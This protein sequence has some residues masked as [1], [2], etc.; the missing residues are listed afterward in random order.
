MSQTEQYL[1]HFD[2]DNYTVGYDYPKKSYYVT[3]KD[4]TTYRE[5][6]QNFL[7]VL[8]ALYIDITE[9]LKE[10]LLEC[11]NRDETIGEANSLYHT[12]ESTGLYIQSIQFNE[13]SDY[14]LCI[15][16]NK[17]ILYI[18]NSN[19][20]FDLKA[21]ESLEIVIAPL[22]RSYYKDTLGLSITQEQMLSICKF[23]IYF[24]KP[25][26]V[27][28]MTATEETTLNPKELYY[29]NT[30]KL[31][32]FNNTS[33]AEYTCINNP[34]NQYTYT[35]IGD[36]KAIDS[37]TSSI[38]LTEP[39][40]E[41][42]IQLYNL[43]ENSQITITGS[44][45]VIE[46]EEYTDDNTYTISSIHGDT[47]SVKEVIP[48]YYSFPY[49]EC[50]VIGYSYNIESIDHE[51]NSITLAENPVSE[52][53]LVGDTIH[54]SGA[55]INRGYTILEIDGTYTV[56]AIEDNIITVEETI[57]TTYSYT[58]SAEIPFIYKESYIG[59]IKDIEEERN[60]ILLNEIPFN[61]KNYY[62]LL[63]NNSIRLNKYLVVDTELNPVTELYR[64]L[65]IEEDAEIEDYPKYPSVNYPL[66]VEDILVNVTNTEDINKDILPKGEFIT[67]N[68][69]EADRYIKLLNG[70]V[71]PKDMLKSYEENGNLYP[72]DI[73][74][75]MYKKVEEKLNIPV[76]VIGDVNYYVES[77]LLI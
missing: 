28:L 43:K 10:K 35:S 42:T 73:Q 54:I 50:R 45:I 15:D 17:G 30:F 52:S 7:E 5:D 37:N 26:C 51:T 22:L 70:L 46:N 56:K 40:S 18:S 61:L 57:P 13:W 53:V 60:L 74:D 65:T 63:Y 32:N 38:I 68:Y 6:F 3:N 44:N 71:S 25:T 47:I 49:I 59:K 31:T 39:L 24:Y 19:T 16:C 34:Y 72:R 21:N 11:K 1:R 77:R 64:T 9:E 33:K 75:N 62:I 66:N 14:K 23:L 20:I 48:T 67:D 27:N 2:I 8:H 41:E 29:T 12:W 76:I 69:D 55:N 36:I 4:T 58:D